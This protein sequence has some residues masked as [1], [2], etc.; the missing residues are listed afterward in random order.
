MNPAII[1]HIKAQIGALLAAF[2]ELEHDMTLRADMIEGETDIIKIMEALRFEA[3]AKE[4][5]I[6]G[7]EEWKRKINV[8]IELKDQ[9]AKRMRLTIANLMEEMGQT[10]LRL[11]I[12][13]ITLKPKDPS[14]LKIDETLLP[15]E[16]FKT[17]KEPSRALINDHIAAG[18]PPPPGVTMSNGGKTLTIR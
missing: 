6:N 11:T 2:P 16:Y 3:K 1:A 12:G 7:L 5:E 9:A 18:N 17:V 10:K 14:I 8:R 4:A 13:S 15:D